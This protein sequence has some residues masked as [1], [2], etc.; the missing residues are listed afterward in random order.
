MMFYSGMSTNLSQLQ[1]LAFPKNFLD[2]LLMDWVK[3]D[4]NP[5]LYPPPNIGPKDFRDPS[6]L[7]IGPDGK[8]RM[9]MGSKHNNTIG[10]VLVFHTTDFIHYKLLDTR[11]YYDSSICIVHD[12]NL[13]FLIDFFSQ[14]VPFMSVMFRIL[15][16]G[17]CCNCI[18]LSSDKSLH[19]SLSSSS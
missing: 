17:C 19:G 5:V 15:C 16:K 14:F 13:G 2:P 4:G 8:Y 9:I 6:N 3:Y 18:F 10:C 11:V 12:S 7:W 1:C